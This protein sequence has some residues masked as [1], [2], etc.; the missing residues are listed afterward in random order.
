MKRNYLLTIPVLL[1]AAAVL[2]QSV[3]CE[4][5]DDDDNKSGIRIT[6]SSVI[7]NASSPTNLLFFASDGISNYAWSVADNSLGLVT[8]SGSRNSLAMYSSSTNTG[9]SFL[10]VTDGA[11]KSATATIK[12]Q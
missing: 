12:Q 8:S 6:P 5:S 3:G 1:V 11:N 4:K 10:T 7:I 9:T 2:I